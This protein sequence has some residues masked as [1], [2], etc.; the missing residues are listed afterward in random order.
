MAA[1]APAT[2]Y[3]NDRATLRAPRVRDD[4][5]VIYECVIAT[6][7]EPLEYSWGTERPTEE[8]LSDPEHLDGL[9]GLSVVIGDRHPSGNRVDDGD[10][11]GL[12]R[13]GAILGA[14]YDAT[15][16]S[17]IAEF[18][19]HDPKDQA[20]LKH[21]R[22]VS[23]AY[24]V[25]DHDQPGGLQT[26]R[27]PNHLLV[28]T[29]G[30]SPSA[31]IRVDATD[32]QE[33]DTMDEEKLAALIKAAVAEA[34][35]EKADMDEKAKADME[36]AEKAKADME[37]KHAEE[38]EEARGDA[39]AKAVELATQIVGL[40]ERADRLDIELPDTAKTP[41]EIRKAIALKLECPADR[42]D[43]SDQAEAWI[44]AFELARKNGV[45][46]TEAQRAARLRGDSPDTHTYA[47]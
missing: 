14:R 29:S 11:K 8:A 10:T 22:E 13:I 47:C 41:A 40:R 16:R 6:A 5:G 7:D 20:S 36:A 28:T 24:R 25:A 27:T 42:A 33:S 23:E 4:G 18:V 37:A 31:R 26:Q 30:R 2:T 1:T 38:L 3:R 39:E 9:K 43:S 21:M 15:E 45:G 19:V 44:A 32:P 12:K 17:V 34:L 35:A 46:E